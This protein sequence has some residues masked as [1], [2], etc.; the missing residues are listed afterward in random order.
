MDPE[1]AILSHN[2]VART[3]RNRVEYMLAFTNLIPGDESMPSANPTRKARL[4]P[5]ARMF[6]LVGSRKGAFVFESNQARKRW[7]LQ[8]PF[9]KGI[10]VNHLVMDTTWVNAYT[11]CCVPR[12]LAVFSFNK[13]IA[14]STEPDLLVRT[15]WT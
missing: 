5:P 15:G 8:G 1:D 11:S 13:T 10:E 3:H 6:L 2:R 12:A 4:K 14:A 9:H 7:S